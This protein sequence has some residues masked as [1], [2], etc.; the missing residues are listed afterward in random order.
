[1]PL[2]LSKGVRKGLLALF[3]IALYLLANLQVAVGVKA[4]VLDQPVA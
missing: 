3:G 2:P 4:P 1:M